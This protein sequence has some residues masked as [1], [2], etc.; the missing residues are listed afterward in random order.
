MKEVSSRQAIFSSRHFSMKSALL[1]ISLQLLCRVVNV[2]GGLR[3]PTETTLDEE[4]SIQSLY[5]SESSHRHGLQTK[6][7]HEKQSNTHPL[8]HAPA[9]ARN[10]IGTNTCGNGICS[11]VESA[12][13]CPA[14]CMELELQASNIGRHGAPGTMFNLYSTRAVSIYSFDFYSGSPAQNQHVQVY[15]R[16][17]KYSG[18]ELKEDGW[19][20]VYDNESIELLGGN[21][22]TLLGDFDT[23]VTIPSGTFQSFFIW[24]PTNRVRYMK[25]SSEGALFAQDDKLQLY[26]GVGITSKFSGSFNEHVHPPRVF[27]GVIR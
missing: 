24:I 21:I 1:L 10:L 6:P 25:G 4:E 3:S 11:S 9:Y 17:G 5:D 27:R 8:L 12:S 20:L 22:P 7:H 18:F 2:Q 14:D 13:S 16:A 23:S 15:T 19:I 26:E